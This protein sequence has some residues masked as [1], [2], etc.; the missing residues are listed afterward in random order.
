MILLKEYISFPA[1]SPVFFEDGLD[2]VFKK[3]SGA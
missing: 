2:K 3:V 1:A